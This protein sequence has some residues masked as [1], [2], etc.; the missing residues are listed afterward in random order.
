MKNNAIKGLI[1][2][3]ALAMSAPALAE[4]NVSSTTKPALDTSCVANAVEARDASILSSFN[5]YTSGVNQALATRKDSLKSAWAITDKT[6]R[7]AA[8]KAAWNTYKKSVSE[9]RSSMK[10]SRSAAWST[11][12]TSSKACGKGA[13]SDEPSAT[14]AVD[15]NL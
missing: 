14:A 5:T 8:L 7:R 4:S 6:Q 15:A 13:S 12:K 10:N 3:S 9:L 11:F 2:A 1:L